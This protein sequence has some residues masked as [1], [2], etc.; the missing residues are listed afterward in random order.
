M[1][2][3]LFS[4]LL[5]LLG[6]ITSFLYAIFDNISLEDINNL[7]GIP[8]EITDRLIDFNN[9][10]EFAVPGLRFIESAFYIVSGFT[11]SVYVY[12]IFG[13][14][15]S[16]IAAVLVT[17]II[18]FVQRAILMAIAARFNI[19]LGIK[20][21]GLLNI[22]FHAGTPISRLYSRMFAFIAGKAEEDAARDEINALVESAMEEG[23]LDEDEYRLMKNVMH[24]SEVLVSDVMTPRTV[25]FS[26]EAEKTVAQVLNMPELQLYSRFPI[27]SGKSLD[28]GA[29]GYVM[30]RD[31]LNAALR[32]RSEATLREFSRELNYIPENATLDTALEQFIKFRMHIFLVVD[33]YGGIEGSISME[34]VMENILGV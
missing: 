17:L 11:T 19:T 1:E 13:S 7:K 5:I 25:V 23:S 18:I 34:D 14:I 20:L 28:D 8:P 9:R 6:G 32:K 21:S 29:V 26:L 33:E 30:T 22:A 16:F 12:F 3:I 24:F 4:I 15:F 31:I 27:W 2:L 10:Q